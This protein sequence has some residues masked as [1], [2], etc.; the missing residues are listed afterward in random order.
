[1]DG[2]PGPVRTCIGWGDGSLQRGSHTPAVSTV[3]ELVHRAAESGRDGVD[4]TKLQVNPSRREL[5]FL[6][7]GVQGP[8]TVEYSI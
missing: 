7:G 2:C 1:M 3:R 8:G 4:G 5:P 6:E